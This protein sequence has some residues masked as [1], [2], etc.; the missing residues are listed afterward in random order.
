MVVP[1]MPNAHSHA[2][3]R[4][5]AGNTE[6]RIGARESFW[7]WRQAMYALANRIEPVDLETVATQ[8][9]IEMLK[10]GYTSVAE[11]H[12]LHRA[13]DGERAYHGGNAL[14]QA[15]D[16]AAHRGHRP[17]VVA[18]SLSKQR[19][20]RAAADARA[21]ALSPGHR[22]VPA[23]RRTAASRAR[24]RRAS[25]ALRTGAAFHSLRAVPLESL[26]EAAPALRSIDAEHAAAHPYRRANARGARPARRA[27]G[28]RPIELLLDTGLVDAHWCLV[29]ATHAP[30]A[31]M[32]GLA[33]AA[34]A[35]CVSPSTEG[36]L[37]DGFFDAA[38]FLNV[39]RAAVH[40]LR[41]P[42]DGNAAEELRW[43][44]Y[45]QRL[46]K[47]RRG[48]LATGR[49]PHVGARS[50]ARA[51]VNGARALG[52]PVGAIAVGCARRLAGARR[53]ASGAWR[54]LARTGCSTAW[55]SPAPPRRSATSWSPAAG[56]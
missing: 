31:E 11:F 10:A 56:W 5:M 13:A 41:Q 45:Q 29:H 27:T 36:N 48:V 22:R 15:I 18:D 25:P 51:R 46:R 35:V 12:Y 7:T 42:G 54:V 1:G 43:L 33:A 30:A 14:W 40:R 24:A 52:Q 50:V 55:C 34:P 32:Q 4:A 47:R 16:A 21:G 38:R 28:R 37:G 6:F 9:F 44:E 20:R 23:R 26:R 17:D 49:E 53:R 39:E 3:Q 2:F 19:L 8:L